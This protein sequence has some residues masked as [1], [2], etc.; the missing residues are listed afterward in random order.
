MSYA[1]PAKKREYNRKWNRAKYWSDPESARAKRRRLYNPA[2]SV[3]YT[4]KWTAANPK[5]AIFNSKRAQARLIG[6]PFSLVFENVIWPETC[7][8]LGIQIR[9]ERTGLRGK[10]PFDDSPSFDRLDLTK[11]YEPGNVIIVSNKANRLRS[12]ATTEE[13]RKV[14]EFYSRLLG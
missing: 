14:A 12:N 11:G 10:R 2:R 6:V 1:D 8:V 5:K 4:K 9:Y 3:A 7:P 13:L